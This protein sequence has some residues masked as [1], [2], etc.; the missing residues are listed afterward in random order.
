MVGRQSQS[1]LYTAATLLNKTTGNRGDFC[2]FGFLLFGDPRIVMQN[3]VMMRGRKIVKKVI[4]N[5]NKD[6]TA[7]CG[8]PEASCRSAF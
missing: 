7:R 6:E 3:F 8:I 1:L 2:P 4:D 5:T